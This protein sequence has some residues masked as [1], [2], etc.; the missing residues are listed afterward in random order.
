MTGSPSTTLPLLAA[1]ALFGG[2]LLALLLRRRAHRVPRDGTRSS[3]RPDQARLEARMQVL[4]RQHQEELEFLVNFPEVVRALTAAITVDQVLSACSRGITTLLGTRQIAILLAEDH[5]HLR[6]VDGAGF[7]AEARGS[8]RLGVGDSGLM[9]ILAQHGVSSLADHPG[10]ARGLLAS[11]LAAELAA[12]VTR[13]DETLGLLLVAGATV[14]PHGARRLLAMMADLTGV[15]LGAARQV[16]QIRRR[17]EHDALTGLANRA[18]LQSRLERELSRCASYQSRT[19]LAMID[20][21]HFKQY[22]DHNGHPAGDEVLRRVARLIAAATRRTDLVARYGGEEFCVVLS[23]ADRRQALQ[24]AERLRRV[25]AEEEF[26]H[27]GAQPLGR[28]SISVGVATFP[29]DAGGVKALFE[30]AD[31]ALYRA[32]QEGRNRVAAA[33]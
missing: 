23:G 32:K 27:G 26:P 3:L 9:E 31:Q 16:N 28:V 30:A 25:I 18:V 21:D 2:A 33:A 14:E 7:P 5:S 12:P 1:L 6:L 10:A 29:D 19:S 17:A 20:V 8:L 11:G 4:E 24:H 15:A 22:N 13:G